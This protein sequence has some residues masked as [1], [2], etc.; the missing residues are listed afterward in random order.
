[1]SI[2][3]DVSI[4][5]NNVIGTG[6]IIENRT[7]IGDENQIS[8][9]VIIGIVG[10]MGIK[11]NRIPEGAICRIGNR[12]IIREFTSIHAPAYSQIT[13]IKDDCNIMNK[14]YIAHDCTIGNKVVMSA[15]VKIG[16][17]C[18]IEDH[19]NLGFNASVHQRVVIGESVMV[20]MQAAISK[21]IIPFCK[22]I[23]APNRILSFNRIGALRRGFD[24]GVVDEA[25]KLFHG[26]VIHSVE[27]P[28]ELILIM[29]V[30]KA[31]H[32][33]LL[34]KFYAE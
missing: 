26:Q 24:E 23:G 6:T 20:G 31:Q 13:E 8:P 1:M 18:Q 19:V 30:F 2:D 16:G 22:V 11:G 3:G 29:Q 25:E 4:G 32:Q 33:D 9:Y 14:C 12:N 15:G 5:N 7:E 28:N 27:S 21:S 17:R 34:K 10:E